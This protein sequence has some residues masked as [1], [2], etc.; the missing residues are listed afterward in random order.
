MERRRSVPD[1]EVKGCYHQGR[2]GVEIMIESFFRGRTIS[3]VRITHAINKYVTDPSEE[4]PVASG[5][6]EEHRA[7][8][9]ECWTTT[10]TDL[11]LVSCVY[12]EFCA[13]VDRYRTRTI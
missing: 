3:W 1:L 11:D 7:T 4:I 12:S 8:C 9:C 6:G 2:Y 10:D 13:K 5:W